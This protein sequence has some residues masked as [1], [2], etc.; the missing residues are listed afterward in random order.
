MTYTSCPCGFY[1]DPV[2][3]YSCTTMAIARY[4]KKINGTLM[5]RIDMYME[6]SRGDYGKLADKRDL[7]DS[8]GTR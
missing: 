1:G 2:K 7:E 3:E 4:Q 6:V 8:R 5:D